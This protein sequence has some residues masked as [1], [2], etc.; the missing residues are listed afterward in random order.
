MQSDSQ[1]LRAYATVGSEEAFA[2]LV[3]RHL[4]MV[5]QTARR[6]LGDEHL[7]DDVSQAVFVLLSQRAGKLGR[8]SV[9]G[10]LHRA[11]VLTA[12]NAARGERR[13]GVREA[14]AT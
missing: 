6:M 9:G 10:W 11:T 14:R 12:R 4:G 1:L 13:R 5:R 2:Q 3:G 7:A 8:E